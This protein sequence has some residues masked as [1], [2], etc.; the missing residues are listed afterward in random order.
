MGELFP[1]TICNESVPDSVLLKGMID[2]KL[3]SPLLKNTFRSAH[4]R[5]LRNQVCYSPR[6]VTP[7]G[8]LLP[9]GI[10]APCI[11]VQQVFIFLMIG[12]AS[13]GPRLRAQRAVETRKRGNPLLK[14]LAKGS[15]S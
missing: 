3:R 1:L 7:P 12:G 2:C 6:Y 11:D 9:A 14:K 8:M 15:E 10:H 4:L 13:E 5:L